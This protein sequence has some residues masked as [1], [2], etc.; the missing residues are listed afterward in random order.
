MAPVR[1]P[2]G[3]LC[4]TPGALAA[5]A[6][7]GACPG[8]YLTRHARGDWGDVCPA[9]ARANDRDLVDGGRLLS[10]YNLPTGERLWIIT[11]AARSRTT[12]LTPD[13]Y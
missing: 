3:R 4:A 10:A 6:R 12:V 7:A 13:E 11:E 1:V 5:L 2:L 8:P 9:D